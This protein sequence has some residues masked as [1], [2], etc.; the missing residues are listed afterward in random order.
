MNSVVTT[1][2]YVLF[3]FTTM[4]GKSALE[5]NNQYGKPFSSDLYGGVV[6]S[7]SHIRL[8]DG[9]KYLFTFYYDGGLVIKES[10][11]NTTK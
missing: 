5:V 9:T 7:T 4:V 10:I 2:C 8:V 11:L 3:A 1:A 6:L